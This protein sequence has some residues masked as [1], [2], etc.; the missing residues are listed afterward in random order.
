MA[1]AEISALVMRRM[2]LYWLRMVRFS[3]FLTDYN[4]KG[5]SF[6]KTSSSRGEL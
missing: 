6:E 3:I 4:I 1:I 5:S 2:D